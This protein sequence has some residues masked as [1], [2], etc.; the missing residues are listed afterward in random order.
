MTLKI[1][2]RFSNTPPASSF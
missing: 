1:S 2:T